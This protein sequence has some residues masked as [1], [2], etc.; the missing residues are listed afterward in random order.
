MEMER[1]GGW[2]TAQ[3]RSR[4]PL[5]IPVPFFSISSRGSLQPSQSLPSWHMKH[6]EVASKKRDVLV[7]L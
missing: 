1:F 4:A 2:C 3:R 6:C 7:L 5:G